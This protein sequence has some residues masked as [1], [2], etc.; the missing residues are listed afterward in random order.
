[1]CLPVIL[2]SVV[3]ASARE[4]RDTTGL[5]AALLPLGVVA[6]MT[7]RWAPAVDP[8]AWKDLTAWDTL[9]YPGE[10]MPP[11]AKNRPTPLK[12]RT[13]VRTKAVSKAKIF[14]IPSLTGNLPHISERS[15]E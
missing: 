4:P 8:R 2:L 6:A 11:K 5:Q 9:G 7:G 15:L 12:D 1:M 13:P 14:V 10:G 3:G